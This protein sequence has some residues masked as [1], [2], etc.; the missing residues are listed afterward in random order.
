M[1]DIKQTFS[2]ASPI[3]E[4][5]QALVDPKI[6]SEWSDAPAKMSEEVGFEFELWNGDISG[7]NT[8]VEKPTKLVQEWQYGDWPKPSIVTFEL[9]SIDDHSEIQLTQTGHPSSEEKDLKEG[10]DIYYLGAI[11]KYLETS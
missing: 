8:L 3:K 7:L 4:V 2:I 10:W 1:T 9:V 6:I 11:K 5:W